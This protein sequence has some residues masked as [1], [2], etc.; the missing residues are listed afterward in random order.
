MKKLM[1][2]GTEGKI[3]LASWDY[4]YANESVAAV[5]Y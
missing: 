4:R 5:W 2:S 1:L 3:L